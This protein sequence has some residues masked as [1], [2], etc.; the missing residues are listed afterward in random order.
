MWTVLQNL[1]VNAESFFYVFDHIWQQL[2]TR[3]LVMFAMTTHSLWNKR[4]VSEYFCDR[5]VN[6]I[7]KIPL[8]I[9]YNWHRFLDCED[10]I[11][12]WQQIN[13][14]TVLQN[15]MANVE[16]IF[17]SFTVCGNNSTRNN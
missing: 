1:M 14:W 16:S 13:M 11:A 15:L 7:L 17:M 3:Q 8:D 10:N 5:Y 9:K 2:N 6:E 12:C 4:Q